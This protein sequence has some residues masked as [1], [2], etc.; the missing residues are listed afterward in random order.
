MGE[1]GRDGAIVLFDGLCNLCTG[2]VQLVIRN[3]AQRW[4]RF[5][6]LS[7]DVAKSLIPA[8]MQL[9]ESMVLI[10]NGRAFT[11][12]TAALRIARRLRW[13]WRMAYVLLIVPRPIRDAVYSL[14]A[15]NR[16]RW[17]GRRESCMV[18]TPELRARF[19]DDAA[20]SSGPTGSPSR[21]PGGSR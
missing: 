7:S 17:F 18:P 1:A 3:D 15:R 20:A 10:E 11:R 13:P 4:F 5:A 12:S 14:I 6:P 9:P 8:G 2:S 19:L 16:Y 21:T